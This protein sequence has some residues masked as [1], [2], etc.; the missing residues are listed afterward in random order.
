MNGH[1]VNYIAFGSLVED[2][3]KGF[4]MKRAV[5][6]G[7]DDYDQFSNLGGCVADV[8]ALAPLLE[9][10]GD[11]GDFVCLLYTSPSPRDS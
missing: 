10:N 3:G 8:K 2:S 9:E 1:R 4:K 6:V 7:I 5:L 11:E